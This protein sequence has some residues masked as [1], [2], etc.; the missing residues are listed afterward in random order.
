MHGRKDILTRKMSQTRNDRMMKLKE[1][2][3]DQKNVCFSFYRDMELW[4]VT[5][6][7]FEFPVQIKE[8]GNKIFMAQDK[9]VL[10]TEY[11]QK[12]ME[13]LDQARKEQV[14][15]RGCSTCFISHQFSGPGHNSKCNDCSDE[16]NFKEWEKLPPLKKFL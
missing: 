16:N 2:I 14:L 9:A 13:M 5:E 6:D 12:H 1:M 8:V 3:K 4:Y 11:I 10:F 15:H 7:G